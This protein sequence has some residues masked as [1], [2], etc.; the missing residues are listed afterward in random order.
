VARD[1]T[2][3]Q[4]GR[5]RA[6]TGPRTRLALTVL[7]HA[8]PRRVGERA[9]L[10]KTGVVE[11]SR[12]EPEFAHPGG[13]GQPL[14]DPYISRKP[15]RV[16]AS[17]SG[18]LRIEP[19]LAGAALTLHGEPM[20][21]TASVGADRLTAGVVLEIGGRVALLAHSVRED[22][23]PT[24]D[25][26]LVGRSDAIDEVRRRIL[27]VADLNVP[28][29]IRGESGA[30]KELVAQAIHERSPRRGGP[31]RSVNMAA[32]AP[33]TA[34]SELFGHSRGAFTGADR[35]RS[36]L[37]RDAD[38]GTLFLDEIG[39]APAELQSML[40]RCL[41]TGEVRPVGSDQAVSVDTR[42]LAATDAAL[43]A[44]VDEG[45]FRLPLLHRLSG[46]E[47]VVPPL[48]DR[49]DDIALLLV[50]FLRAELATTGEGHR[51]EPAP[52]GADPWLSIDLV[53]RLCRADWPGNVRQLRNVARQL[54]IAS[55]GVAQLQLSPAVERALAPKTA[56]EPPRP[57]PQTRARPAEIDEAT[58]VSTLGA[59]RYRIAA[60]AK[61]LG[62]SKT[63]L[64][65]LIEASPRVRKARDLSADEISLA[66]AD[67]DVAEAAQGLEVSERGLRLRMTELGLTK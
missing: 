57:G 42:V 29:L 35:A 19:N 27:Q 59:H 28:V 56:S 9:L 53:A 26:G 8:D 3:L 25:C 64:Y 2:T 46:F 54:A 7:A 66:I 13:R 22:P 60:T 5:A 38:G 12:N 11:L 50:H 31:F 21:T 1:E 63:S 61:A 58:L 39:E 33:T 51:L 18:G 24:D 6:A 43:E 20:R 52:S 65:A 62:I 45:R 55:R 32:I 16:S 15:T 44:A 47:L 14:D 34:T 10:P 4:P 48:R 41:E 17:P 36:G 23:G 37:F 40:L 67:N 30:G 49:R